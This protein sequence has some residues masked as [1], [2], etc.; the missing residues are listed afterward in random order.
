MAN[1][2][3]DNVPDA[4]GDAEWRVLNGIF[5]G[6]DQRPPIRAALDGIIGA[7]CAE[8]GRQRADSDQDDPDRDAPRSSRHSA[9]IF[10]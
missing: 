7:R 5:E 4:P 8:E 2:T 10:A 3:I 1:E 9:E 6:A